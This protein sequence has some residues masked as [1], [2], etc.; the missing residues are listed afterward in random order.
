FDGLEIPAFL[1][2]PAGYVTE[3]PEPIPFV[4]NYHGGPEGQ[5]RPVFDR[6]VQYLLSEGFGV[7]M[8]NVR[9]STGYGRAFQMMDD[10]K[11][12]WNSVKDGVAA[13]QWLVDHRFAAPGKIATYGGS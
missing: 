4:V 12:R 9:G 8:P 3:R 13:A 10:Y 5:H 7:I 11:N 1:Y 6:T 2:L